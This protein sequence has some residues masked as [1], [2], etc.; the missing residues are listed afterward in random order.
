MLHGRGQ[1]MRQRGAVR[2]Q[3]RFSLA[4]AALAR[5]SCPSDWYDLGGACYGAFEGPATW[6]E[7]RSSCESMDASLVSIHNEAENEHAIFACGNT[8]PFHQGCWIGGTDRN[9]RHR[10]WI[11]V[12]STTW[13]WDRWFDHGGGNKEP[14]ND[15]CTNHREC[16]YGTTADCSVLEV[17]GKMPFKGYWLD[18]FCTNRLKYICRISLVGGSSNETSEEDSAQRRLVDAPAPRPPVS[19]STLSTPSA[20]PSAAQNPRVPLV[21][22]TTTTTQAPVLSSAALP[23]PAAP[24]VHLEPPA[25]PSPPLVPP[26]PP[27]V[28]APPP[29]PVP[30]PPPPVPAPPPPPPADP[31]PTPPSP[32][33]VPPPPPPP[34][35]TPPPAP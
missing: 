19:P 32:P 4:G 35:S 21:P 10:K 1:Q 34:P 11:W 24:Q 31:V 28:P 17:S 25:P 20:P 8:R 27:P 26:P 15:F 29:P 9:Q 12:D 2:W 16:T 5:A 30:T 13:D 23:E 3:V 14:N 6:D 18:T 33:P 7:A 22:L